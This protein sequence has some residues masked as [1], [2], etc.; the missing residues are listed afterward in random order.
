MSNVNQEPT[1]QEDID[2]QPVDPKY[3]LPNHVYDIL[4]WVALTAVPA[5]SALVNSLG[6]IWGWAQASPIAATISVIGLF[7][8]ALLGISQAMKK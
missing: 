4:K 7:I 2:D 5:L 6:S 8:G 3:L 1:P